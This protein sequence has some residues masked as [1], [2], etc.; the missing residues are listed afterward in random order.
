V[1]LDTIS[2]PTNVQTLCALRYIAHTVY[3]L[4]VS[5]IHMVIFREVHYKACIEILIKFW[6][7]SIDIKYSVLKILL[8][9]NPYP[10]NVENMVSS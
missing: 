7:Q 10:A 6:K 9:F 2:K 4:H 1:Y 5:A 8:F 3:M